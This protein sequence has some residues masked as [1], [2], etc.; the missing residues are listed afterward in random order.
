VRRADGP[1]ETNTPGPRPN[2][3]PVCGAT[4]KPPHQD[5]KTPRRRYE[6]RVFCPGPADHGRIPERVGADLATLSRTTG[7]CLGQLPRSE[8]RAPSA[9]TNQCN[10]LTKNPTTAKT[11]NRG[12]SAPSPLK[13]QHHTP[14]QREKQP[15]PRRYSKPR[16]Q[17]PAPFSPS[18]G[19][20]TGLN[21]SGCNART[22]N[23]TWTGGHGAHSALGR[24]PTP[25]D[26]T[27]NTQRAPSNTTTE[28][29]GRDKQHT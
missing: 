26:Q 1:G 3:A 28:K 24:R 7:W 11:K 13:D 19:P 29:L 4:S 6:P 14:N 23:A 10:K 21:T 17:H 5:T 8:G 15:L 25:H 20:A 18:K 16:P 22:T 27:H 2:R 9:T 12:V